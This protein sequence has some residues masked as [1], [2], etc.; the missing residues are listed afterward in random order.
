M[1]MKTYRQFE[2]GILVKEF[3]DGVEI[4][5]NIG[6]TGATPKLL[7][8]SKPKDHPAVAYSE[9]PLWTRALSKLAKPEDR[10]I[11]DVVARTIGAENSEAFKKWFK[12]TTGK[13]CGCTGRQARYNLQYPL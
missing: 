5:S 11:G 3:Q 1:S 4:L 12:A 13:D 10:G 9:W 7:P 8:I 6:K 2:N